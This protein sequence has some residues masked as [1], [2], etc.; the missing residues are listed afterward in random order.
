MLKKEITF[1]YSDD[2]EKQVDEMIAAQAEKRGYS[3]RLTRDP[4][5]KCEIGWYCQHINFPRYSRFSVIMLHDITQQYGYWPDIWLRE[6]WNKY[7]IGFLPSLIWKDN[8]DQ[9]SQYYY[10][11]PR[12]G[13]YL[14][15]WPKA[16]RLAEYSDE[17]KRKE[18]ALKFGLDPSRRT[19]V[20]APAWENDGKQD[21]F[22]QSMLN[23][24]VN[25]LVKQAPWPDTYPDQIRNVAEMR[26]L[27]KDIKRVIQLDPKTNILD[28]IMVSD[29][30]VSEE[31]STMCEA[32]MLGKPAVSVSNWMVPFGDKLQ[33]P[34]D[35]YDFVVKTKKEDL[36]DCIRG[37]LEDYGSYE[38]DAKD[39]SA[40]HFSNIGS[41]IPMMLDILDAHVNATPAPYSP[42]EPAEK[43]SVPFRR[44]VYHVK[45]QIN[46]EIYYNYRARSAFVKAL[47]NIL[48]KIKDAITSKK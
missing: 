11:R 47:W 26:E 2:V 13:M 23:L 12:K 19:V 44:N 33:Y 16:D 38:K 27:H 25:I 29:I 34:S 40:A 3:V 18:L 8:W 10:S 41:C 17:Q 7:D 31:S 36:T 43:K 5:A 32:V 9:C 37:I 21:S 20:Y 28:A 35:E 6:P 14:T 22:V 39:Y 48:K 46:R 45:E 42:L 4:Y 24:D 30:L 15:G 1:I